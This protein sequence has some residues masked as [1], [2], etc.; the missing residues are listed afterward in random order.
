M[1]VW[2]FGNY[3]LPTNVTR[4][5]T[6]VSTSLR[7]QRHWRHLPC[8]VYPGYLLII[9]S[10]H[11]GGIYHVLPQI[12]N[13][14]TITASWPSSSSWHHCQYYSEYTWQNICRRIFDM[15]HRKYFSMNVIRCL[16]LS[17]ISFQPTLIKAMNVV[18]TRKL[19]W[20]L[21][22]YFCCI[23]HFELWPS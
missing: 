6:H 2:Q 18:F 7:P 20:L 17:S 15:I 1:W 16:N 5:Q 22:I 4:Y 9:F 13:I 3:Y 19:F 10:F 12:S 8:L 21:T 14:L 11:N 23:N